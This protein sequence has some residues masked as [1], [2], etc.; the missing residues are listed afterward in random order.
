MIYVSISC[1]PS[2]RFAPFTSVCCLPP[3]AFATAKLLLKCLVDET[4]REPIRDLE[5]T[6]LNLSDTSEQVGY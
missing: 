6:Q 3:S 1:L 2:K 4:A 5:E